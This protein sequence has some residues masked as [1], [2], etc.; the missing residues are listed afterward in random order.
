MPKLKLDVPHTLDQ[1]EATRRLKDKFAAAKAQYH[2]QVQGLQDQW[3]DHTFSFS[4]H[5]MGMSVSGTVAV[6]PRNIRLEVALP[7][8][9][10]LFKRA[11]EDRVRQ[12]VDGLL[13]T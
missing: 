7:L 3:N 10:M 5:A 1:E 12:E 4:L 11:I 13:A 6:Q 9:A 8:A 2:D